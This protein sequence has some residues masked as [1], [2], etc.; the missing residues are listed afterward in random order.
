[1][2]RKCQRN[3]KQFFKKIIKMYTYVARLMK[4]KCEET[5]ISKIKR[6]SIPLDLTMLKGY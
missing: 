5:Q 6:G 4:E 1:M 3:Q 2:V